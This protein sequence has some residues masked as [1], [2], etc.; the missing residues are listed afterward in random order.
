M[1]KLN[2]FDLNDIIKKYDLKTFVETGTG[3]GQSLFYA[4]QH[5]FLRFYSIEFNH[6]IYKKVS[7]IFNEDFITIIHGESG[8]ELPKILRSLNNDPILFFLDAHFPSG[9]D[10]G[11]GSYSDFSDDEAWL[12]IENELKIIK[13]FRPL[14]KD[15]IIIDDL[16]L[17]DKSFQLNPLPNEISV[18]EDVLTLCEDLFKSTHQFLK[19]K[20]DEG[21]LVLLPRQ[22]YKSET[23]KV[24]DRILPY[25]KDCKFITDIGFGGD[26]I[27]PEAVGI[28][29]EN[30]YAYTGDDAV[31]IACD[32]T[33]G[34]PVK[35]NTYDCVYS[36]HLVEDFEDTEQILTEFIRILKPN[37]ILATVVPNEVEYKRYCKQHNHP[38]NKH[39]KIENMD[40]SYLHHVLE[41]MNIEFEVLYKENLLIDYNSI[42]IVKIKS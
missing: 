23:S 13:E 34:I 10:F 25:I 8:K 1:G 40:A 3:M 35:D 37:G 39:H 5:D 6:V 30:P 32:V 12:P 31:N 19:I 18:K 24:R 33:K 4:A 21:Y 7:R 26:K 41:S 29:F 14:N 15:I 9:A 2:A 36:S 38:Y 16:R 42:L 22:I 28:D 17:F 20:K 11:L 27:V